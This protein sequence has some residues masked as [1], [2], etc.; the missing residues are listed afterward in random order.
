MR[1]LAVLALCLLTFTLPAHA[2]PPACNAGAEGTIIYNK[3][4]KIVQFCNG[5]QWIGM[6]AR[7]GDSG[8]TLADLSCGNGE[9]AK[10]NGTTWACAA[11]S[12]GLA[13]L[14][15]QDDSG[16]C[17]P[18]KD[19]LIRYRTGGNPKWE[20]CDGGTT[21]WLP[22][23]LPQCQDNDAGECT[24]PLSRSSA[25]GD[26]VAA[27]IRC[28]LNVLG[29]TGTYDCTTDPAAFS[30]TDLTGQ[31]TAALIASNTLTPT[32]YTDPRPVS[33][34]GQGSPQ[35]SVNGGAWVTSGWMLPGYTLQARL[36]SASAYDTPYAATVSIGGVSDTWSVRTK[37]QDTTPDAFNFTD[38]TNVQL[39]TLATSAS[40]TPTGYDGPVSVSVSG[41]G[42]PQV[43]INGG[44]WGSGGNINPG[45][46]LA[47]RLTSSAAYLTT[48]SATVTVGGTSDSWS[49]QTGPDVTVVNITGD[50]TDVNLFTLAG[51]PS[52]VGNW[53][54]VIAAGAR[55]Y[56][57]STANAA[58]TV[59]SFPAGSTVKITNLGHVLGKGGV[60]GHGAASPAYALPGNPGEAGGPAISLGMNVS[61]DNT[62]GYIFGGGGGGGGGGNL[63]DGYI[64]LVG[65]TG[66]GGAGNGPA[67][68]WYNVSNATAPSAGTLSGPGPGGTGGYLPQYNTTASGGAGGLGGNWGAV[69]VT[70]QAGQRWG[71]PAAVMGAGGS[72]GA[73]GKAIN[74][75]GKTITWLGGNDG[76]HVK[77]AV[78]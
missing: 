64:G 6:V 21:S 23:K 18:A 49:V 26:L 12:G 5:T 29:V 3:D 75:N 11:D 59:G 31:N 15:G 68:S 19:G 57:T 36:T 55:V 52:A 40:I 30:F 33:V 28:G 46:T 25:D 41:Q 74:I 67:G 71:G 58:L 32:G 22:F 72:G 27:S 24:L 7:I 63:F 44:A 37:V 39:S 56:A 4:Y 35:I 1:F 20:Y 78:N 54:F 45:E 73:A 34:S 13:A 17:T 69:G 65:G 10:W 43:S 76:T 48:L 77:G 2:A 66:G 16:A 51:G 70:G 38:Q 60:G 9:I 42:S 62:S 53:E 50:Q 61:I 14:Q 8:D 47:V